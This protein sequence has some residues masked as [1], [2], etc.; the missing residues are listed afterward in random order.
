MKNFLRILALSTTAIILAGVIAGCATS[1]SV[2]T[3]Q[4]RSPLTP[5]KVKIYRLPPEEYEEIAIIEASSK[6][7]L[8]FSEQGKADAALDRLKVE[9]AKLG[10]NGILLSKLLNKHGGSFSIGLGTDSYSRH[11]G[12]SVG[13][14]TSTRTTY[15]IAS[16]IAIHVMQE[17]DPQPEDN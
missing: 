2:V 11:S 5:D 16:G 9:A 14:G 10:A 12:V 6:G 15:K 1:S 4:T 13:A 3:G 7:S 17:S 8:Q